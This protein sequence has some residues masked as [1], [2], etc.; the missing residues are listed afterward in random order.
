MDID[1]IIKNTDSDYQNLMNKNIPRNCVL[2]IDVETTGF[3]EK[4][5][6]YTYYDF[7]NVT[8][9]DNSRIVQISWGL[10]NNGNLLEMSDYIIKPNG[11]MINNSEYHNITN[12][13]ANDKGID[14]GDVMTKLHYD[15]KHHTGVIVGHN[16]KFD[17]NI[18]L[19]ELYRC[20]MN[21]VIDEF[22]KKRKCCTGYGSEKLVKI[23][24]GE[25]KYKMPSLQELYQWCFN[26]HI[27]NLHN[28]KEDVINTAKCYFHIVNKFI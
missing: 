20:G 15:L 14:I 21:N 5:N 2:V 9:Y 13:I 4:L 6:F 16:L 18:I 19:S 7:T 26:E 24:L 27:D 12:E 28:S 22:K 3:P 25:G 23:E 1:Q 8:K 11:F 10:Y 17:E